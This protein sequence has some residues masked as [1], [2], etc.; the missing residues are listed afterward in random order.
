MY[1]LISISDSLPTTANIKMVE[2]WMIFCL[3]MPFLEVVLQTYIQT[4]RQT[5]S[6]AME[7]KGIQ[8]EAHPSNRR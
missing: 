1:R 6:K 5:N 7:D 8:T 2:V 3:F 4:W